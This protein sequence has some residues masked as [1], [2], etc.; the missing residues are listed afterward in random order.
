MPGIL[1]RPDRFLLVTGLLYGIGMAVVQPPFQVP[2]EPGHFYR[3]YRVSEGR[4]DLVPKPGRAKADLPVSVQKVATSLLG[5][6]PFHPERKIAPRRILAAF[7]VPLEPERREPAWFAGR[8]L[9]PFFP[10]V[11]Q[12]LAIALGRAFEAPPLALLYLARLGN[13]LA[14]TLMLALAVRWLPAYRWLAVMVALTPMALSLQ[15]SASADVTSI[16]AGFLLAAGVARL[17]WGE[18][19]SVRRGDLALLTASAAVLCASKTVYLPLALLPL[20]VPPDRFPRGKRAAFLLL[21]LS[22]SL[23]VTIWSILLARTAGTVRLDAPT[24]P[25]R[26]IRDAL[27]HPL[28]FLQLVAH[29]YLVHAPRYLAQFVG[30]LG[31]LDTTLPVAFQ[32]TY[33]AVLLALVCMDANPKIEIRAWQRCLIGSLTLAT[34]IFISAS[35]YAIWTP[36]GAKFIEGI[37]GRYF[38]PLAPAAVWLFHGRGLVDRFGFRD[39]GPGLAAFSLLSFGISIWMLIERFFLLH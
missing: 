33:L 14:G 22:L 8:S 34:L 16:G 5:D 31:W 38:L 11:P 35:Q 2:D 4:L 21:H 13:V 24:D 37:Q 28:D 20:L 18:Q 9:Y 29:D 39:P 15:G 10:Y 32:L 30:K 26:Q 3:A 7:R 36:Y 1:S 23:A 17:A 27:A 12:A 25:G 19:G 6:L